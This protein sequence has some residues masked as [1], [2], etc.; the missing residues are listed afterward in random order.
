MSRRLSCRQNCSARRRS[1]RYRFVPCLCLCL[2]LGV[3]D[4]GVGDGEDE[5]ED[6]DEGGE[7]E[8]EGE[9]GGDGED[10]GSGDGEDEGD[11]DGEDEGDG[12]G[13]SDGDGEGEGEGVGLG[14]G[15]DERT[16]VGVCDGEDDVDGN[17]KADFGS[18]GEPDDDALGRGRAGV[19][20]TVGVPTGAA[21]DAGTPAEGGVP[22]DGELPDGELLAEALADVPLLGLARALAAATGPSPVGPARSRTVRPPVTRIS[23]ALRVAMPNRAIAPVAVAAPGLSRT[24]L[25]RR[26][27]VIP[28]GSSVGGES[29]RRIPSCRPA[30]A[31]GLRPARRLSTCSRS[32]ERSA[33]GGP[34]PE[35]TAARSAR[36]RLFSRASHRSMSCVTNR[37]STNAPPSSETTST[38]PNTE[39]SGPSI[40]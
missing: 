27:R 40:V 32:P 8:D 28:V 26:C 38:M 5:D 11:G 10:E 19:P 22:D 18:L 39:S 4:E 13:E 7:D 12:D 33:T 2:C 24:Q 29:A 16:G 1:K 17:G 23:T 21:A 20:G 35:S 3:G 31:S 36:R 15:V 14:R 9:G 30:A 37:P 6:E 34:R 25:Q